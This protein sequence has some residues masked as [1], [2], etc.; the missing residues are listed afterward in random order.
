[1]TITYSITDLDG[2]RHDQARESAEVRHKIIVCSP[3]RT[4]SYLLCEA[5]RRGGAGVP[6][7][8]FNPPT[9]DLLCRRWQL[10]A[11]APRKG[12]FSIFGRASSDEATRRY[13]E[14][15]EL[16]R[17]RNAVFTAKLQYWQYRQY[18]RNS[19]GDELMRGAKFVYLYRAAL[20]DQAISLR[21][22]RITGKWGVDGRATTRVQ[23]DADY[24][25]IGEIDRAIRNIRGEEAGWRRFF[26]R[27]RLTPVL[28]SYEDLVRDPLASARR[29]TQELLP[30]VALEA[31]KQ[32]AVMPDR[33]G[34]EGGARTLRKAIRDTY[35]KRRGDQASFA[36]WPESPSN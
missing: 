20:L 15:L 28:L 4:G 35:L 25:D 9:V 23:Q 13:V 3:P 7:E 22:A 11:P 8:Y 30:G 36:R 6:H 19:A 5:M 16:R 1:M 2:E 29:V 31:P 21:L 14:A 34:E 32:D 18:L 26:E 10:Q 24:F 17:S 12:L 33:Q 27:R